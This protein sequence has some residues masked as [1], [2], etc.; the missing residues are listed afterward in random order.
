MDKVIEVVALLRRHA[1]L[2]LQILNGHDAATANGSMNSARRR[3]RRAAGELWRCRFDVER[4]ITV[5]SSGHRDFAFA[6]RNRALQRRYLVRLYAKKLVLK[7][8]AGLPADHL[9]ERMIEL[10]MYAEEKL[11][12][13][14]SFTYIRRLKP[15][16]RLLR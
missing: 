3:L 7:N 14:D 2:G 1:D 8:F 11:R 16:S 10:S 15:Q 6:T 9:L 12:S 5:L 13:A 4:N